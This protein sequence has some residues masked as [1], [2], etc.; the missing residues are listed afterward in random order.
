MGRFAPFIIRS[1]ASKKI[2]EGIFGV[3]IE[4]NKSCETRNVKEE[5][6]RM[7]VDTSH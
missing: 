6:S 5:L 4:T 7:T 2:K 3:K 1:E